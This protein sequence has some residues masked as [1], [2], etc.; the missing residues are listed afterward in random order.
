MK[1]EKI[2]KR[3][4]E[5]WKWFRS[6]AEMLAANVESPALVAELDSRLRALAPDLSWELGPG[7]FS[8]CQLVISPDLDRDR[9]EEARA[10]VARAPV[11]PSWEFHSSRQP[12][13]WDYK[14]ELDTGERTESLDASSWRF[15]LLQHPDGAHE[16]LIKGNNISRLDD[17]ERWQAAAIVLESILGEDALLDRIDEFELVDQFEAP[18]TARGRPIQELREAIMG[19]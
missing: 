11:L 10:T 5:F 18:F 16:I 14:V 13:E 19:S 6:V 17:K 3:I 15:V 8:P 7:L 9:R 2:N 4:D 12:K 1:S